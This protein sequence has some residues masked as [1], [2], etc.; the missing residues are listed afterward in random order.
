MSAQKFEIEEMIR[1]GWEATKANLNTVIVLTIVGGLAIG[2]PS[3]IA[4]VL[5]RSSPFLSGVFR[6]ASAIMSL[7]VG[8][9][10]LRVSL[11]L[12]DGQPVAVGDLFSADW[13]LFSRYLVATISYSLIVGFG[14]LLLVIPGLMF[15]VRFA[16]YGYF[17]VDRDVGPHEALAQS[18]TATQGARLDLFLLGLL[19]IVLNVLGAMLLF[20]G[21]LI[22]IPVS[23]LAVAR[24]YRTLT[25]GA[26]FARAERTRES[27]SHGSR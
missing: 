14:L 13:S 3:W 6:L 22:S 26:A 1:D 21:L 25:G 5:E 18:E 7:I 20:I 23:T 11:R 24:A 12:L 27:S 16:F 4:E 19:L 15:A 2:I 10:A 17:V 9:G 8:I